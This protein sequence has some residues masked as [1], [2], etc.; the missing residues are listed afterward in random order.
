MDGLQ[1]AGLQMNSLEALELAHGTD[2][3]SGALVGVELDDVVACDGAVVAHGAVASSE[4]LGSISEVL[5]LRSWMV[6]LV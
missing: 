2:S 4:P 1:R 5:S 3:A 6:K